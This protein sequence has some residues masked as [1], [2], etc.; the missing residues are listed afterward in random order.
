MTEIYVGT[1]VLRMKAATAHVE[2]NIESL[3]LKLNRS[4]SNCDV[5][6][7]LIKFYSQKLEV[8]RSLLAWP[9]NVSQ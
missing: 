8:Q 4:P 2:K 9:Q 5:A 3:Q 6:P 7:S 1:E